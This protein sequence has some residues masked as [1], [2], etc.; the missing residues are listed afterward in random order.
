MKHTAEWYEE[1]ALELVER[2]ATNISN[3]CWPPA[4]SAAAQVYATLAL[5]AATEGPAMPDHLL[6]VEEP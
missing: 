1:R 2:Y 5:A 3:P 6:E 4:L